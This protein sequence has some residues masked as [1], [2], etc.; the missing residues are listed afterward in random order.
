MELASSWSLPEACRRGLVDNVRFYLDHGS[1]INLECWGATPLCHACKYGR[2]DVATLLLDH[3]ADVDKASRDKSP[4]HWACIGRHVDAARLCLD[5][6][7][8]FNRS[9]ADGVTPLHAACWKGYT[10]VAKLLLD[11]GATVD[12][13][14]RI[15]A[16]PLH[17]AAEKCNADAA[18]LLLERGADI[19]RANRYGD[20]PYK[21]ALN[22]EDWPWT[23]ARWLGEVQALGWKRF[24]A[25]PRYKLVVLRALAARGL[26]RRQ[27]TFHGKERL[28]DLLFP[29][30]GGGRPNTRAKQGQPCLPDDVFPIIARYYWCGE[31]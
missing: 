18:R 9:M 1:D 5:R 27:R 19:N 25:E 23:V 16:T 13:A 24:L 8:D 17:L 26:V 29:V 11:R 14:D 7:A 22:H 31:L 4:L 3:N 10:E 21:Y 15:A 30:G 28:L 20:T 2:T 12:P 6:G